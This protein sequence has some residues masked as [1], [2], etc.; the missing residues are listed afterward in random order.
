MKYDAF[1]FDLNGTMIDDM[2]YHVEAW[3]K[4]LNSLGAQL[5]MD[6]VKAECYGKNEELLDRIF[7]GRFTAEEKSQMIIQKERTYQ[8]TFRRQLKLLPGL[9]EFLDQAKSEEIRM[10]IGTAAIMF[11][12]DFVLD[13]LNIRHYFD[14]IVSADEVSFSKPH[15]E[16]WIRCA[17]KLKLSP[18]R[19]LVFEDSPKGV[20]AARDAGM[21]SVAVTTMHN[22][23][24]FSRLDNVVMIISDFN[25]LDVEMFR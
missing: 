6:R 1:L 19:C 25:L 18:E 22:E 3:H 4:I 24:E 17:E 16:T 21:Q 15:P 11:N 20:E 8:E 23:H 9:S 10:A 7:P 12:V 2:P 5:T 14:C 13:G